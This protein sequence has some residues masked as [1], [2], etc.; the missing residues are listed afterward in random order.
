MC[1]DISLL[2]SPEM[3]ALST[4]WLPE[5]LG[6]AYACVLLTQVSADGQTQSV[7]ETRSCRKGKNQTTFL[8]L[9]TW[10]KPDKNA[11]SQSS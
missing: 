4:R 2:D 3:R 8:Y 5:C 7:M 11:E 9:R 1:G 10:Q 6:I